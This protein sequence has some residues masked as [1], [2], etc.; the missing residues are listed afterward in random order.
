MSD[1][2]LILSTQI[3]FEGRVFT[4]EVDRVRLPHGREVTLDIIRH[5]PSVVLLPM[6]DPDHI[7]LIRQYRYALDRWIWELPAGSV[8]PGESPEAAASR[9]CHEEI[10]K[11]PRAITR[12][13]AFYPTPGYC[14][15]LMIYY[16]IDGLDE[17]DTPATA[18]IDE[19]IEPHVFELAEARRLREQ[20]EIVDMKTAVGLSLIK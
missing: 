6:P 12:L 2:A 16:R 13:G 9:E 17:A 20:G 7:V 4:V 15:E 18:D 14:D 8:D 3:V 5:P 10:G 1:A 19:C 11:V